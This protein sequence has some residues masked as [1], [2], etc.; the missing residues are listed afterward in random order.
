MFGINSI[1]WS[2]FLRFICFILGAWYVFVFL[3]AWIKTKQNT[4]DRNFEDLTS[5]IDG[6]G[7]LQPI[8]VS[9]MDYPSE[10]PPVNPVENISLPASLYEETGFDDG[11]L[12]DHFAEKNSPVLASMLT[13]IHFQQ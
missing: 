4:E 7:H 6:S 11:L 5:E 10:I 12:I 8:A 1:T 9:A 13:E 3:L 2:E